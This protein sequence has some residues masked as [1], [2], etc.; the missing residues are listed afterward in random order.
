MQLTIICENP[1]GDLDNPYLDKVLAA[2]DET[3]PQVHIYSPGD[4]MSHIETIGKSDLLV[5][6]KNSVEVIFK[7]VKHG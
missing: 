3:E 5:C 2:F 1:E 7:E 6:D 4:G